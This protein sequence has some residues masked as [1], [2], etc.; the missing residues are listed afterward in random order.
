[1]LTPQQLTEVLDYVQ[2]NHSWENMME[3]LH[4]GRK[5]IKY[6]DV[7]MDTR[8]GVIWIAKIQ[9]RQINGSALQTDNKYDCVV[10]REENCT[11]E[12]IIE[13]LNCNPK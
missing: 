7:T 1:M 5:V 10:F 3:N 11:K 6:V 12:K 4:E 2:K 13:W 8:D 9:F